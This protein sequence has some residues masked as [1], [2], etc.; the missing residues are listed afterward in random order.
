[1]IETIF[2]DITT[3]LSMNFVQAT[4]VEF[5][6]MLAQECDFPL[7]VLYPHRFTFSLPEYGRRLTY[8]YQVNFDI[9]ID[10]KKED[11]RTKV[12]NYEQYMT[13]RTDEVLQAFADHASVSSIDGDG[14]K[15]KRGAEILDKQTADRGFSRALAGWNISMIIEIHEQDFINYCTGASTST[16][17][18]SA[19][20]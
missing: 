13:A 19:C 11:P 1:M 2:T 5:D 4:A 16:V 17:A 9:V 20:P 6:T 15:I 3:S 14:V 7:V 8:R 10:H 12:H 18:I